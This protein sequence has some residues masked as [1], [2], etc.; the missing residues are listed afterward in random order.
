MP[1]PA[2]TPPRPD[3]RSGYS[4]GSVASSYV[5]TNARSSSST[6]A[7]SDARSCYM[8]GSVASSSSYART[9][10]GSGPE[11]RSNARSTACN[12]VDSFSPH[13]SSAHTGNL[14]RS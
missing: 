11:A 14:C 9:N 10:A 7:R 4:A 12:N 8:S 13:A 5:P 6:A 3:A 1:A 2:A